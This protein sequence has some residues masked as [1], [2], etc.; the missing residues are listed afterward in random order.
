MNAMR[1]ENRRLVLG[2]A[3]IVLSFFV[4]VPLH[5]WE[6]AAITVVLS[7]AMFIAGL[8]LIGNRRG[9][10]LKLG[11]IT[12]AEYVKRCRQARDRGVVLHPHMIQRAREID[13]TF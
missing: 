8:A 4:D 2:V 13:P 6:G 1:F 5:G 11:V 10:R 7:I 12:P 9:G 3:L